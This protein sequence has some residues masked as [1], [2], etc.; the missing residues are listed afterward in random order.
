MSATTNP[1]DTIPPHDVAAEAATVGAMILDPNEIDRVVALVGANDFYVHRFTVAAGALFRMRKAGEKIDIVTLKSAL[2]AR[3]ELEA[4]GGVDGLLEAARSVPDP[5]NSINYASIVAEKSKRR[6]LI[7]LGGRLAY[8]GHNGRDIADVLRETREAATAIEA[9]RAGPRFAFHDAAQFDELDLRR[10]YHIPG[11]LAAGGVP[12]ILA[13]SFK[14][15]KTSVAMDMMLSLATG[16]RFLH[17]FETR[18][19]NVAVMSG[20]SGGFALQDLARR[21]IRSKNL[22]LPYVGSA[23]KICTASP[24][25]GSSIDLREIERFIDDNGIKVFAIDPTYLALRSLKS[26]AAGSIFEMA[27][28]LEPLA[29]IGERT[30]CTPI[31]VHHNSRGATRANPNE[32]AELSDIAWS[33]FSEWAGQWV[34]LARR[35]RFDPDSN[36]EHKLWLTAGGRDGHSTLVGVNVIEGTQN[37]PSGRRWEAEVIPASEA[38]TAAREAESERREAS[39]EARSAKQLEVDRE[40]VLAAMRRVP[41]GDTSTGIRGRTTLSGNRFSAAMTGLL[42]DGQLEEFEVMKGNKRSYTAY[43]IR[44]GTATGPQRD[45]G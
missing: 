16:S 21:I 39:R 10:E 22:M 36:G 32:P 43:R 31:L 25:L 19:T 17:H 44:N 3:G 1:F 4:A 20:E 35:E 7:D 9:G 27:T 24:S 33:G 38:R 26:D 40:T 45:S 12:T 15:L 2:S 8:A 42:N 13:G 37:D 34:L 14:T 11:V 30:G 23:F 5:T 28:L 18:Q 29:R 41:A 6:R